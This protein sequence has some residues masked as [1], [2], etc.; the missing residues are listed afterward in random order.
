M[1]P[2]PWSAERLREEI[3][4]L[5][6][7]GLPRGEFFEELAPRLRRGIDN[8]ASCWH[9]L[10][11][12]TRLMTADAPRELVERGVF[13]VDEVQAAGELMI[14]S[15]YLVED[16]NTFAS[17]AGRRVPVSTLAAATRGRPERST[18]Y[19]ELLEPAGIPH[20]LRAAFV[21]RGRVW[22]AVHLARRAGSGDFSRRDAEA[23]AF[24][25]PA[26]AQGIRT[27]LR[28]DA[29]RRAA[30]G[31]PPGLIV[32]GA[33]NEVELVTAPARELLE[34]LASGT[35]SA[36]SLPAPVLAVASFVRRA[37]PQEGGNVVTVPSPGGWVTLHA[38]RE[39]SAPGR[40][41]IVLERAT[42]RQSATLRLELEGVT[43][44]EREVATLLA[45]GLSNAEIAAALVL[46]PHTVQDHVKS[47]YEKV[48]VGSRQELVARVFLDEYRPE[49]EVG[50]PITSRGRF[51]RR[52]AG[53]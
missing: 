32:L 5:G 21:I 51:E 14:R 30:G 7:R 13:G 42:A 22:G 20:E 1:S 43:R 40:V 18:R 47:V 23:L 34:A 45:R 16:V 24:V 28:F 35:G 10:D 52:S 11:P 12:Q 49:L 37:A 36:G 2:A 44:R 46:S 15:E 4:R 8:D 38:S 17:L 50:T 27:S 9:T 3:A 33:E 48:G 25:A 53:R 31:E 39:E 19:R 41:A 29:A 6:A 26:I